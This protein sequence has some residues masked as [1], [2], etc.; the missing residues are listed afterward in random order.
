MDAP[1]NYDQLYMNQ[2][3]NLSLAR[4]RDVTTIPENPSSL[5]SFVSSELSPRGAAMWA[6]AVCLNP[7]ADDFQYF[8]VT[9]TDQTGCTP[10]LH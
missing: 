5:H 3:S 4:I 10:I 2:R 9:L 6:R 8:R 1:I 7:E